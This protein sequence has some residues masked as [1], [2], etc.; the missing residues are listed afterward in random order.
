VS[1]AALWVVPVLA[2]LLAISAAF[3]ASETALFSLTPHERTR[4]GKGVERLLAHPRDLLV[5]VLLGNLVTNILFFAFA[6]RLSAGEG[7]WVDVFLV[8]AVL[9]VL[10]TCGEILPKTV[11]LRGRLWIA[12]LVAP[13]LLV[14]VRLVR[15][16]RVAVGRPLDAIA[17]LVGARHSDEHRLDAAELAQV[18]GRTAERGAL[19]GSEGDLLPEIVE[20]RGVRVREI[21]TPRVDTLW[22]D[23]E[24]ADREALLREALARR[25]GWLAV[26]EGS[27]DRVVGRVR[28][29]DLLRRRGTATRD[30]VEPVVFVPEVASVLDLLRILRAAQSAEA[31]VVDEWG[32]TAGVVTLEN[33]FEEIL[34]DL[35]VEG[36]VRPLAVIPQGEGVFRVAGAMGV[37]DWNDAFGHRVVP[38]EF[39]TVG[40]FVTA[41]LGRIP[42]AGDR[43]RWGDLVLEVQEARRRR[44]VWVDTWVAGPHDAPVIPTRRAAEST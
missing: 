18:L 16:L 38:G 21:M 22:L 36:E 32:G 42:R 43:V 13:V 12:P 39:E 41:L 20:L 14:A 6:D 9:A 31:V 33:V 44:V 11:G 19:A 34:G 7:G 40:G 29:R 27:P 17:R 23:C 3:S 28:L 30:L 1:D 37:R 15:P 24:L 10:L 26:V 25:I 35:R 8:V 2:G 4:S 5:A